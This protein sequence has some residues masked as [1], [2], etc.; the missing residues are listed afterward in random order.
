MILLTGGPV[1]DAKF[2]YADYDN[3]AIAYDCK[4]IENGK[5]VEMFWLVT[6]KPNIDDTVKDKIDE[7][8]D[9]HFD[10]KAIKFNLHERNFCKNKIKMKKPKKH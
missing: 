4:N 8:I 6:T 10:R 1:I 5:S 2:L 3:F 9:T 7:Y